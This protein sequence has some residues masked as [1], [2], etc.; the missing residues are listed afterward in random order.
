[1]PL[2]E[3]IATTVVT[4]GPYLTADGAHASGRVRI[5]PERR[6]VHVPSG[7]VIL[8]D[9]VTI[10]L[11]DGAGSAEVVASDA[12]GCTP[13]P[14]AYWAHWDLQG[15]TSPEPARVLLT[16]AEVDADTLLPTTS[17]T[18]PIAIPGGGS[19]FSGAYSDLAGRPAFADVATSGAYAD[20]TGAP[21]IPDSPD[22]IG[23][24]PAGDYQPAGSY[25]PAG[26]Y[27]TSET[28]T[29]IV[30]LTQAAYDALTP[31]ADTLYVIVG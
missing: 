20:L 24:Q 22:D 28:I 25:Q 29:T 12:D 21:S 5:A 3:G 14:F 8:P 31:D 23:A 15:R 26:D 16:G 19:S 2:P 1:M 13:N 18:G 30:T 27:V 17:G 6:V 7:S 9:G 4:V 10:T 11:E